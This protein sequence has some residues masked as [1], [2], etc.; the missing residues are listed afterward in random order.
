MKAGSAPARSRRGAR[1]VHFVELDE[2]DVVEPGLVLGDGVVAD[3]SEELDA[4]GDAGGVVVVVVVVD[5]LRVVVSGDAEGEGAGV[6]RSR[7]ETRSL[8]SVQPASTPTPSAKTQNP[9]SNFFIV[10]D[11]LVDS[12]PGPAGAMG[13]PPTRPLGYA[14][15][16]WRGS[17]HI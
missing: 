9:V 15:P 7:S 2:L 4:G 5:S 17:L 11:L 13:V 16:G 3:E 14:E 6:T 10:P 1:R 8:R 12:N